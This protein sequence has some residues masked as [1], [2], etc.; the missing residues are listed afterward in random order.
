VGRLSQKKRDKR[1]ST[2]KKK[3]IYFYFFFYF[4]PSFLKKIANFSTVFLATILNTKSQVAIKE[5][6]LVK[7]PKKELEQ[8]VQEK[9]LLNEINHPN[10]IKLMAVFEVPSY[11]FMIFEFCRGG[12][13]FDKISTEG[14]KKKFLIFFYF[15]FCYI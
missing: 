11:N 13:L 8:L 15:I 10:I 5:I 1:K 7:L 4:Y 9:T 14:K 3:K 2:I 12:D 6:D